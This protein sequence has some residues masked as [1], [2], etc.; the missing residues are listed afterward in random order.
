MG[1]EL[2]EVLMYLA[3]LSP[4]VPLTCLLIRGN[5][6]ID[7]LRNVLYVVVLTAIIADTLSLILAKLSINNYPVSHVYVLITGLLLIFLYAHMINWKWIRTAI[8]TMSAIILTTFLYEVLVLKHM[9]V[10]NTYTNGV[11]SILMVILSLLYFYSRLDLIKTRS[12]LYNSYFWVNCAILIYFGSTFFVTL[13]EQ[14]VRNEN[15]DL[16]AVT[17]TIQFIATII[18]N[19]ILAKGVW[20]TTKT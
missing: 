13:F 5:K 20:A 6:T 16:F 15:P 17:W 8:I 18:F 14:Y 11:T 19:L 7:V 10:A 4:L 12:D 3:I 1:L 2:F 9:N